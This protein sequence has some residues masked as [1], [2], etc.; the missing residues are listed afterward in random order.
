MYGCGL[1]L[2]RL[3]LYNC[4]LFLYSWGIIPVRAKI[5][6]VVQLSIISIKFMPVQ[7]ISVLTIPVLLWIIP[8]Q[9]GI[10]LTLFIHISIVTDYSC[11]DS[12][13]YMRIILRIILV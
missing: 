7:I 6:P 13:G 12:P 5:I 9:L 8:E 1:F 2:Y 10:I 11:P 4:G 3:F